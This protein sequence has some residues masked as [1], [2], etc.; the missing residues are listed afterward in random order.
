MLCN[1][2]RKRILL[3]L[4]TP[5]WWAEAAGRGDRALLWARNLIKIIFHPPKDYRYLYFTK[6]VSSVQSLSRVRLFATP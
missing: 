3:L 5:S 4:G 2:W 1:T 6:E